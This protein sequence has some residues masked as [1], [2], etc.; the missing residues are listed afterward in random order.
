[1]SQRDTYPHGVPCWV[2][3]GQHDPEAAL[4]FY[5]ELFGW[6]FKG[7]GG[8]PD[9]GRYFVACV[10]GADVAGIAS[11]PPD[12]SPGWKTYVSVE[13][14]DETAAKAANAGGSV[15]VEPFDAM[16]AGRMAVLADPAGAVFCIWQPAARQGAQRINEPSA[17]AMSLLHTS[18]PEGAKRFY[19][20]L[21]GWQAEGDELTLFRLPGYVGG[22]PQQPVPRD[23]VAAMLPLEG[24]GQESH[25]SVDLWIDD[26][27]AAAETASRLG[28]RVVVPPN[29]SPIARH[30][31]LADPEGAVFSVTTIRRDA[32]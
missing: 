8:M 15:L 31:V 30:A 24:A 20:E 18:D 14:A 19:A 11:H 28:G 6:E 17:W 23:V 5:G 16:P 12:T 21:F 29:D 7:P 25:W 4:K 27:D 9:H 10:D 22:E 32:L 3:A 2:D 26:T 1:M 13:S